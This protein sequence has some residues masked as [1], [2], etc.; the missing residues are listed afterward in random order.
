MYGRYTL[1]L[2]E[3]LSERFHARQIHLEMPATYNIAPSLDLPVVVEEEHGGRVIRLM[4]WGLIPRRQ[5]AGHLRSVAPINAR[6]ESVADKPM[7]SDLIRRRRCLVPTS[8]FY[9]WQQVGR[10]KRPFFVAVRDQPLFAFAGL[11]DELDQGGCAP[12]ASFAVLTTRA[13]ARLAEIHGRMPVIVRPADEGWWL[14]RQITDVE[15]VEPAMEPLRSEDLIVHPVSTAV[16]DVRHDGPE[17]IRP[18]EPT[19]LPL[20]RRAS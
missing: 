17:L 7:F 18:I 11:Y 2:V 1:E 3:D 14:S 5:L 12:I 9:E 13:N 20:V 6:A 16:N 15:D 19:Q 4:Q 10:R 8:G